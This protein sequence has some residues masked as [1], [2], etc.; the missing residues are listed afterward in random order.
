MFGLGPLGLGL[1]LLLFALLEVALFWA[2]ASLAD[3]PPL[4]WGKT[5]AV[6]LGVAAV[7]AAINA[8]VGW[9]SGIAREPLTPETR[10]MAFA[11]GALALGVTWAVPA[12]LYTPLLSVPFSRGMRISVLQVLLRAFLYVLIAAAVMV[13]LAVTQIISAP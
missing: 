3:A 9:S 6:A 4:G 5:F 10:P 1:F 7:W 12:I 13:V 11:L 8:A 2:A